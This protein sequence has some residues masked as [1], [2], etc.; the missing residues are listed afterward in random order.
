LY[1]LY[2]LEILSQIIFSSMNLKKISSSSWYAAFSLAVLTLVG[3]G[4]TTSATVDTNVSAASENDVETTTEGTAQIPQATNATD[5]TSSQVTP[6]PSSDVT[7]GAS[8]N[9]D[10]AVDTTTPIPAAEENTS[11]YTDGTYSATGSY[12]SPG[13]KESLPV[14]LTLENDVIVSVSVQTPATNP[15]SQKFQTIFAENFQTLVVGKNINEVNLTKV[16]GSSLA[17]KG[18]N[19][20]VAKIRVEAK[21]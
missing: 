5:A 7:A 13:G 11:E 2:I 16:S 6:P 19:D 18:F 21:G 20:A 15:N 10:T 1:F 17:P 4:C 12:T 8:V 9:I 14:T 3:A